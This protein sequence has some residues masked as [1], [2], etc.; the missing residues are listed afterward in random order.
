MLVAGWGVADV[1]AHAPAETP[2]VARRT[3]LSPASDDDL[4]AARRH[5]REGIVRE[6]LTQREI[7]EWIDFAEEVKE[8]VKDRLSV[9][10]RIFR[11]VRTPWVVFGFIAQATFMM[12]FVLQI[13]AS[14]RKKRSYVPVAFWYL[15]LIG[16]LMLFA[17]ALAR[18]DPV[19]VLGQGLGIGIYARNLILIYRR[20]T[21]FNGRVDERQQ[22]QDAS[23]AI[24]ED[25]NSES[26]DSDNRNSDD[27]GTP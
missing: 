19:F 1:R 27:S 4:E 9:T 26:F 18:R 22:R 17:Y 25:L 8:A 11:A 14:E 13:I 20:R 15:S 10:E 5:I 16:G 7:I 21:V 12:R 24:G 2:E 23:R 3:V 6:D